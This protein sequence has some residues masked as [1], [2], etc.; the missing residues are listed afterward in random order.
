MPQPVIHLRSVVKRYPRFTLGPVDLDVPAGATLG[1]IGPNG[2]GK[3][4]LIRIVMGLVRA[5]AGSVAV[6][7]GAMPA[8]ESAIKART[9]FVSEDMALYGGATLRWHMDLVRSICHEWDEAFAVSLLGR[10]DID[11]R[12]RGRAMSRG[13]QVK[14]LLVLALARRPQL[15]VLDEPTAGLDPLARHEVVRL[16]A[17]ERDPG[18]TLV[19]SSH[20][21]ADVEELATDVAFVNGGRLI[22]LA[23]AAAFLAGGRTLEAA[24]LE[25]VS[26]A[27]SGRA[28]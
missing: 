6:L 10:L 28:A 26:A 20:H 9:G 16:L 1:L 4:T 23:P 17:A 22:A 3:S 18:T 2:A 19:F 24:F 8:D 15:I 21:G 25:R 11:Q 7:N 13:Q 5:D 27:G 14:A 12:L